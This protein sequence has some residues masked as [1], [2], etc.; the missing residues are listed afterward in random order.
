VGS[1][2][3]CLT[4]ALIYQFTEDVFQHSDFSYFFADAKACLMHSLKITLP[5]QGN[6]EK[7]HY[8]IRSKPCASRN[9]L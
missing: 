4:V 5:Y 6:K 7:F 8:G 2:Q 3:G 1:Q 9:F